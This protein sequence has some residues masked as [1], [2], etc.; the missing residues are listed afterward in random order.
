MKMLAGFYIGLEIADFVIGMKTR[1]AS[2]QDRIRFEEVVF[3]EHH[4]H[5]TQ[6]KYLWAKNS[7]LGKYAHKLKIPRTVHLHIR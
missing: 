1:T 2:Q 7:R 4:I 3:E 5:G 6:L